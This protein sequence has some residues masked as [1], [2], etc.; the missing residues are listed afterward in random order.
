[1][2]EQTKKVATHQLPR[3][4]RQWV[5]R[6]KMVAWLHPL[7]LLR[8]GAKAMQLA[9]FE[10]FIDKREL[11]AHREP[12]P[13]PDYSGE[14]GALWVDY[15]AD[16]GDGWASTY[17]IA[18]LLAA[19]ELRVGDEGR[20]GVGQSAE[21]TSA[22]T[23]PLPRGRVLIMGGDQVYPAASQ[24]EY[25][26]RLVAPYEA[27]LP[28]D[29][30]VADVFAIPGNHDWYD[31]LSSF[32]TLFARGAKLGGR[33]TRQARSY[34]AL[35]LR[36]GVWLWGID[37]GPGLH[38][39]RPQQEY[40]AEVA[41]QMGGPKD[42]V[43]CLP[44]PC[45]MNREDLLPDVRDLLGE[46]RMVLAL[47][48]DDHHYVRYSA[49][50]KESAPPAP[51]LITCGGGG[52]YLSPTHDLPETLPFDGQE[53]D[54]AQRYP[55]AP[56]SRR[57]ANG[58]ALLPFSNTAF[59]FSVALFYL[60]NI[61]FYVALR[62]SV[63]EATL[64][65][66]GVDSVAGFAAWL[67][68]TAVHSPAL[69]TM[70]ASVAVGLSLWSDAASKVTA[71]LAGVTH[72]ALHYAAI[73]GVAT[74]SN[75][76]LVG[77]GVSS[78]TWQALLGALLV[79]ALGTVAAG[80]IVAGYLWTTH[81]VLGWHGNEVFVAQSIKH[82]KCFLRMRIDDSTIEIW[83]IGVDR[84]P[85]RYEPSPGLSIYEPRAGWGG[86]ARVVDHVEVSLQPPPA[87][88]PISQSPQPRLG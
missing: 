53:L 37:P 68:A 38:L 28:V 83:A 57:L 82:H 60:V 14:A 41:Q 84:V 5:E 4:L 51:T 47:S 1:M 24:A 29:E 13:P 11:Q 50:A 39:D 81:R 54:C 18:A 88:D 73:V 48:G 35:E 12:P 72:T 75:V 56:R 52:A 55:A 43:L 8:T 21:A 22:G 25:E 10:R 31:G 27:A 44:E 59:C 34:F 33:R 46:H 7:E 63:P 17:T 9:L 2:E 36:R 77:C 19:E 76:C 32:L 79:L 78:G 3:G 42:V 86:L 70:L 61:W 49:T 66:S 71:A 62:A 40:F 69:T 87:H 6:P 74:A 16:V 45:W 65:V 23:L 30:P 85:L 26:R 64:P 20:V 58:V 67:V 80:L 15:V